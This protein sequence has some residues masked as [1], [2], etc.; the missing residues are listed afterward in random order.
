MTHAIIT[1]QLE[2]T[3][4]VERIEQLKN[5]VENSNADVSASANAE[6]IVVNSNFRN[7]V[8]S[9]HS[10]RV[11]EESKNITSTPEFFK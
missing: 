11:K 6:L 2:L 9:I 10:L 3:K 8:E 4:L 5:E 1:L 7:V